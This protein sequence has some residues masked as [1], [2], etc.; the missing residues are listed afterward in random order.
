MLEQPSPRLCAD[1]VDYFL[2]D[3]L[4]LGI[5]AQAEAAD[6]FG[7]LVVA[8]GRLAV[9]ELSPAR[10]FGYRYI[11]AD[12]KSWSNTTAILL[13]E[14]TARVIRTA[15]ELSVI[16]EYDLCGTDCAAAAEDSKYRP[17]CAYRWRNP[18][19]IRVGQRVQ[20]YRD[21]DLRTGASSVSMR[22]PSPF[23]N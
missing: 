20:Y 17:R 6:L 2:R 4:V 5:L 1:R 9:R 10:L 21:H 12:K 7:S 11:D 22:L 16:T 13:Y 8:E 23:I 3:S 18:S 14:L 15:L 19:A